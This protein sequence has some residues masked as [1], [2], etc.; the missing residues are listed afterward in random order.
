M[1]FQPVKIGEVL[2]EQPVTN[3]CGVR[4]VFPT[5][6]K[7]YVHS[8][9]GFFTFKSEGLNERP[10]NKTPVIAQM[11]PTSWQNRMGLSCPPLKDFVEELKEVRPLLYGKKI[12]SSIFA[13][14]KED[15]NETERDLQEVAKAVLPYSDML[16]LNLSCP[17]A[18][19]WLTGVTYISGVI[20]RKQNDIIIVDDGLDFFD[21]PLFYEAVQRLQKRVRVITGP[22]TPKDKV[23]KIRDIGVEVFLAPGRPKY[24][25]VQ[26]DKGIL[27]ESMHHPG[28]RG[29]LYYVERE[30][31][32]NR[33]YQ[34][35]FED[36]VTRCK[37]A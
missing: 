20:R 9:I 37:E 4:I 7:A 31:K 27:I 16:E 19:E 1:K 3:A 11:D 22:E 6:A 26:F 13:E 29:L 25:F 21:V 17:H 30:G 24:H 10:G 36:L 14:V 15:L 12:N 33:D 28:N 8:G 5:T 32:I 2:I 34:R 23:Q 35:N 18:G